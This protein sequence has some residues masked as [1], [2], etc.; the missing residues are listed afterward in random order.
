MIPVEQALEYVLATARPRPPEEV[1]LADAVGRVLQEALVAD[2]DFPSGHRATMDGI[3]LSYASWAKGC[4]SFPIQEMQVAGAPPVKLRDAAACIEIMTGA[5]LDNSADTVIR[6]E[7]LHIE[8]QGGQRIAH[9]Q[10]EAIRDRQNVQ[11]RASDK[12]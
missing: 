2:R 3:A 1:S 5:M 9:V 8:A 4:R 7:D 10:T 11:R 12:R 6:Y